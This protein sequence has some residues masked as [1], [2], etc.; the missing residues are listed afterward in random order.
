MI[1]RKDERDS[2]NAGRKVHRS[3][4]Q[5]SPM[6][7]AYVEDQIMGYKGV[8][9][10]LANYSGT[11]SPLLPFRG[12]GESQ[13][14]LIRFLFQGSSHASIYT[15]YAALHKYDKKT[16]QSRSDKLNARVIL[17]TCFWVIG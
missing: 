13:V 17:L 10:I 7:H 5:N 11:M 6:G 4:S 2:E 14:R 1:K 9:F 3:L 8:P 15:L 16:R 12:G